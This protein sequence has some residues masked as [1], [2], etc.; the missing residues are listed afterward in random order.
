MCKGERY[1]STI[2]YYTYDPP[3]ELQWYCT[4][5]DLSVITASLS[6]ENKESC[7]LL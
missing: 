4:Y 1:F 3:T 2:Q 7:D 6:S 5:L